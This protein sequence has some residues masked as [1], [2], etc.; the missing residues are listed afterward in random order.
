MNAGCLSLILIILGFV[1]SAKGGNWANW[2][3]PNFNGTAA[4]DEKGLPVEF[5][6]DENIKWTV[7]LPGVGA[8]TPAVWGDHVF[9]TSA[10]NAG[11]NS[12][13]LAYDRKSGKE[14]WRLE[15]PGVKQ[16]DRS[17]YAAPSAV[18]DGKV[19]YFFFGNG[20]LGCYDFDGKEVWR[21][22]IVEDYGQFAFGWTFSTSPVLHDG[23]LFLQ[24][25]QR[26]VKVSGKG[27]DDNRS[28]LL[29]MDP[30]TGKEIYRHFRPA[31]AK[32]ESLESFNTPTPFTHNGRD[33]ILISGGDCISGHNPD[34]GKELWRWGTWNPDREGHW[35]LV[36][37]PIGGGGVILACAPKKHPI[38]G[39]KAG[40]EG[41]FADES[42]LA[43]TSD[44]GN[45]ESPITSDVPTPAFHD[46]NFFI[47][48]GNAKVISCVTPDGKILG[49]QRLDA[50]IK[51]EAS[52][53]I[54]DGKI[55]LMSHLGEIYVLEANE[56]LKIL[57]QTEMGESG[58]NLSRASVAVS[59]GNLFIRTD[60]HLFCVG[61]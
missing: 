46:G 18:T 27:S 57:H 47:L 61:S 23:K 42:A 38:Y 52:P 11:E 41:T 4:A 59:Q 32:A 49:S 26:D 16:D 14:L 19:V 13:A 8:S 45:K 34:T 39:V 58:K 25:C 17:N 31:S 54:A 29:A 55:Y 51:F 10:N 7:E 44:P 36:P 3:G 9:L 15:F 12:V 53:T 43:W 2:R 50:K 28:Y 21:R 24:V 6:K 60:T 5:S 20:H 30:A 22:N 33:E 1:A 40:L 48:A 37:S 56:G 35:R